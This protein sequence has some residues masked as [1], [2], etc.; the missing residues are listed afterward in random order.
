MNLIFLQ[1]GQQATKV[2]TDTWNN[3]YNTLFELGG[4]LIQGSFKVLTALII[5]LIFWFIA[6]IVSN[7][8]KKGLDMVGADKLTD[9]LREVEIFRNFNYSLSDIAKKVI[10]YLMLLV[11]FMV[12]FNAAGLTVISEFITDLLNYL[13]QLIVAAIIFVVGIFIANMIAN[14]VKSTTNSMNISSGN[15]ISKVVFYALA[16]VT[17]V[18][19][20]NQAGID[21]S[22]IT[23][24]LTMILGAILLA[25]SIAFG[26]AAIPVMKD[27]LAS[28]YSKDRYS[29]GQ[30]ITVDGISGEI[31]KKDNTTVTISAGNGKTVVP[32]S[33][34]TSS[35]VNI[36]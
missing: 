5:I 18:T 4:T 16:I 20:L 29:I 8:V 34:L 15:L 1:A 26:V 27:L 32:L 2:V 22:L 9:K 36:G 33:L 13:P 6:K 12:A 10:Y 24:N 17:T 21:T 28:F 7:A 11:G 35:V 14:I 25:F 19:A 3:A 23:A 30:K 31:V